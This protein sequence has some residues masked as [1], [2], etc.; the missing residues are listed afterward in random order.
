MSEEYEVLDRFR[1]SGSS[2]LLLYLMAA[3][4]APGEALWLPKG[5]APHDEANMSGSSIPDRNRRAGLRFHA[6]SLKGFL[7]IIPPVQKV[8][9]LPKHKGLTR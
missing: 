9:C 4:L 8:L 7:I 5:E 1:C 2:R 3:R 6:F